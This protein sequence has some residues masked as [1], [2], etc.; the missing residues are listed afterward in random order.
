MRKLFNIALIFMLIAAF[1]TES[2]AYSFNFEKLRAPI[3]VNQKELKRQLLLEGNKR[4]VRGLKNLYKIVTNQTSDADGTLELLPE[5]IKQ[6]IKKLIELFHENPNTPIEELADKVNIEFEPMLFYKL[7]VS[8]LAEGSGTISKFGEN[9]LK[10]HRN[11]FNR[12]RAYDEKEKMNLFIIKI[13]QLSAFRQLNLS[14][15]KIKKLKEYI[16]TADDSLEDVSN[17]FAKFHSLNDV[18]R[19]PKNDRQLMYDYIGAV[20]DFIAKSRKR[21]KELSGD[22]KFSEFG[23]EDENALFA[24]LG[25]KQ[26]MFVEYMQT[27]ELMSPEQWGRVGWAWNYMLNHDFEK[28]AEIYLQL[29]FV[30]GGAIVFQSELRRIRDEEIGGIDEIETAFIGY[31]VSLSRIDKIS[32]QLRNRMR[33]VNE[34]LRCL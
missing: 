30:P 32:K 1:S 16:V 23:E 15:E 29:N 31:K 6:V 20:Y 18:L 33:K 27:L 17:K 11:L 21:I 9:M 22:G 26:S 3:G 12:D 14:P 25:I 4:E 5:E 8:F 2:Y 10:K 13:M 28:A 7:H 34:T 24:T 19:L